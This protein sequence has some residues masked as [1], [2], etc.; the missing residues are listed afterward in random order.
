MRYLRHWPLTFWALALVLV[1]GVLVVAAVQ[2]GPAQRPPLPSVSS[3]T[4]TVLAL[5]DRMAELPRLVTHPEEGLVEWAGDT[6]ALA[7]SAAGSRRVALGGGADPLSATYATLAD[8]AGELGGLAG[9]DEALRGAAA[10]ALLTTADRLSSLVA[11]LP[12]PAELTPRPSTEPGTDAEP[13]SS[14]STSSSTS[15]HGSGESRPTTP[16]GDK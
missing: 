1:A 9:A 2:G 11:G 13:D 4:P 16:E 7:E 8:Q 10:S 12:V 15:D 3:E 5:R 6:K 14:S